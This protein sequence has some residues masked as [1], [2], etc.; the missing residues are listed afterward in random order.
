[1]KKRIL[2]GLGI[3][4]AAAVAAPAAVT[5][6][7]ASPATITRPSLAQILLADSKYDRNGFDSFSYDF[8]VVTQL[9]LQ[10]PDLVAAASN[11]GDLTV[12]LP[13]DQAFRSTLKALTGQTIW[14]EKAMFDTVNSLGSGTVK[15]VLTYHIVGGARITYAQALQ[16]DGA[17]I[18]TLNGASFTVDV[19]GGWIK[20]VV[21]ADNDPDVRDPR[22]VLPNLRASNGIAHAIDNVLLPVDLD[23]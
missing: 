18:P 5:A 6:A 19:Q 17:A 15:A 8:D 3:A 23:L 4:L 11:P 10:Y 20:T 1:M 7:S 14:S 13:T 22:V 12:F 16:S 9:V 2:A 21:L